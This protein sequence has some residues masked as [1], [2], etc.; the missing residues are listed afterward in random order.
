MLGGLHL[1]IQ[2]DIFPKDLFQYFWLRAF[3]GDERSGDPIAQL[4]LH[5]VLLL[6]GFLDFD[7]F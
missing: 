4:L 5:I 2:S 1:T 3:G 6:Q 7:E